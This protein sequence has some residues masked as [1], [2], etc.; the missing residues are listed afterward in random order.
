[1]TN[2]GTIVMRTPCA[3]RFAPGVFEGIG[4]GPSGAMI[5]AFAVFD[6]GTGPAL[7]AGG[8]FTSIAS[9]ALSHIARWDGQVWKDVG[10]GLDGEVDA[11]VVFD[12][13]TGT[14]LYAGGGF[15]SARA[16]GTN[17]AVATPLVARWR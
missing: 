17:S 8:T 1:M 2:A 10:G 5:K 15:S 16:F 6:D 4:L 3:P 14:A 12:D 11:L 13:G 7:Y 9:H